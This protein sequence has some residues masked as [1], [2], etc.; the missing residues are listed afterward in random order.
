MRVT[1]NSFN[2]RDHGFDDARAPT[3]QLTSG[4]GKP[5]ERKQGEDGVLKERK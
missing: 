3:G 5:H 1:Q 2:S 4:S